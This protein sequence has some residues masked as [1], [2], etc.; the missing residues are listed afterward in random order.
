MR[1]S[2]S[3]LDLIGNT[4][5]VRLNNLSENA[6]LL[7][8]CEFMNP[9]SVKDR[10]MF[11]IIDRAEKTGKIKPG[12]TLIETTSGNTGMALAYIAAL[13][14]Y[15]VILCMSSIQSVE[16]RMVMKALGAE[17]ELTDASLGTK[18][19]KKRMYEI[20]KEH[21]E[22]FYVGQHVNMDNPGAHYKTTGPEL[23]RDT[24]G[25]IDILVAGLGTGGTICGAG[26]YLKE[27]NPDIRL[28][29]IEPE[30]SPFISKGI[31]TA[32]R[33]MGTAP[34]F[35]PDT[36]DRDIIDDIMLVKEEDAFA[37]CRKLAR[38]Q[39]ILVGITSGAVACILQKIGEK[40]ENTRKTIVGIFAD[41]GERYLSVEGLFDS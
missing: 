32:H 16:R 17:L 13:K 11:N 30:S 20:I 10:P 9:F 7:A 5:L 15:K 19:A 14:G 3:M 6:T 31:F 27:Q 25:T 24:E 2:N 23:W 8:K 34:G 35:V 26:K 28:V 12:D 18:G 29:A 40:P 21:P 33:M 41:S 4:P 1:Y 36:L 38:E 37:M 39:G 22:Y